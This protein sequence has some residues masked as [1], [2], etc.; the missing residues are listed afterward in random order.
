L[1]REVGFR[2]TLVSPLGE[3]DPPAGLLARQH[4]GEDY[5]GSLQATVIYWRFVQTVESLCGV[6][7]RRR[8]SPAG[9]LLLGVMGHRRTR[10]R[11]NDS[12][13]GRA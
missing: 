13:G 5:R 11:P 8:L 9:R 6:G 7:L 1:A 10:A 2:A 12:P 3:I 4:F